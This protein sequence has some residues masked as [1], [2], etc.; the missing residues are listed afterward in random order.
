M[1]GYLKLAGRT[2]PGP[3]AEAIF[4]D[5]GCED[6]LRA[7]SRPCRRRSRDKSSRDKTPAT[8]VTAALL[9]IA[10]TTVLQAGLQLLQHHCVAG[11]WLSSVDVS[12]GIDTALQLKK[13]H[14]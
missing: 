1:A 3:S 6:G 5:P 8:K 2:E 12:I 14:C 9:F 7:R 4:A 10:W 11:E 13:M